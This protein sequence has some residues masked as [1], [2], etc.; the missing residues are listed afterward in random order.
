MTRQEFGPFS[1]D[2]PAQWN[3]HTTVVYLDP[4]EDPTMPPNIVISHENRAPGEELQAHAWRKL[5]EAGKTLPAFELVSSRETKI[6]GQEAFRAVYRWNAER[7]PV[8]QAVAWVG[9]PEHTL[10]TIAAT[11]FGSRGAFV[12]L[13]R[14]LGSLRFGSRESAPGPSVAPSAPPSSPEPVESGMQGMFAAVPMPGA[15]PTRR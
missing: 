10:L 3:S 12:E 2:P 11:S 6:A 1:F 13:D 14:I 4:S 7:G 15:R 9:G 5:L 8:E